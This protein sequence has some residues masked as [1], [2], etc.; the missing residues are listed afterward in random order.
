MEDSGM[1]FGFPL[2]ID[3]LNAG[4]FISVGRAGDSQH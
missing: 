3:F 2:V 1:V 4:E